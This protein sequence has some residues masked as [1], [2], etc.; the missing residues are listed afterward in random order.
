MPRAY[1]AHTY[2][3]LPDRTKDHPTV[4]TTVALSTRQP[5]ERSY[6]LKLIRPSARLLIQVNREG[7]NVQRRIAIVSQKGGVGKTTVAVTLAVGI[8]RRLK[9][10]QKLLFIDSDPSGNSTAN[11]LGGRVP[12]KPGLTEVLLDDSPKLEALGKIVQEAIRP[13]RYP[14]IDLLPAHRSLAHCAAWLAD[15]TGRENRLRNA[16]STLDD[17]YTLLLID[18][19]PAETLVSINAI[20]AAEEL[21]VP[22]DLA[23]VYSVMGL[24]AVEDTIARIKRHCAHPTLAL[25]GLVLTRVMKNRPAADLEGNFAKLR[26]F[27]LLNRHPVRVPSSPCRS[28]FQTVLEFAPK[29]P[30][31][32]AFEALVTEVLGTHERKTRVPA[33][34]GSI[35]P[36]KRKRRA[37]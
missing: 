18:S 14:C 9:K 6:R 8:A 15:Q 5:T 24:A 33:R 27:G 7:R 31:G 2:A 37:S 28:H 29:S 35:E 13:S 19:S 12:N 20:H 10:G 1:V 3:P 23:G 30:A 22:V 21:I 34:G 17:A 16:L 32:M 36:R 4:H 11:L 25:I 26:R